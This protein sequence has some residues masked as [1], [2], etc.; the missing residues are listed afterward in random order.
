ML[1][2]ASAAS[3]T[4]EG[5][6]TRSL[7]LR[8]SQRRARSHLYVMSV[9]NL[10]KYYVTNESKSCKIL[11]SQVA[12]FLPRMTLALAR[13]GPK[14]TLLDHLLGQGRSPEFHAHRI[15]LD[16][17]LRLHWEWS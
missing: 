13:I 3:G 4:V 8:T 5:L 2:Q 12:W 9:K 10:Q 16:P 6:A 11:M 1:G 14:F 7:G 15:C 17:V